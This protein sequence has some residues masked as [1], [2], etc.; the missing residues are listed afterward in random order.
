MRI[1]EYQ[2][3]VSPSSLPGPQASPM[4]SPLGDLAK[5]VQAAAPVVEQ[6]ARLN[7]Q[8]KAFDA[9]SNGQQ[10][11]E[12]L[13]R[14]TQ[15]AMGNNVNAG[16][17]P[18]GAT[19]WALTPA[20]IKANTRLT[21]DQIAS[22]DLNPT[23]K[24]FGE[25]SRGI[26]NQFSTQTQGTLGMEGRALYD[27]HGLPILNSLSNQ[28]GA[29]T[30]QQ[31]LKGKVDSVNANT[32][33]ILD[34]VRSSGV[35]PDGHPDFNYLDTAIH[36][37][38]TNARAIADI[39]GLPVPAAPNSQP[40]PTAATPPSGAA[41][42]AAPAPGG[43]P[44]APA[45]AEGA[46]AA[47]VEP[48]AGPSVPAVPAAPAVANPAVTGP[49]ATDAGS[50]LLAAHQSAAVKAALQ[51]VATTGNASDLKTVYDRY[52]A[53]LHGPDITE[54]KTFVQGK[55]DSANGLAASAS[56]YAKA[57]APAGPPDADGNPPVPVGNQKNIV[58]PIADM[59]R[60]LDTMNLNPE[61][62][63]IAEAD[64]KDRVAL[65]QEQ[66]RQQSV[67]AIGSLNLMAQQGAS[68][69]AI[70]STA[71]YCSLSDGDRAK[72]LA[73]LTPATDPMAQLKQK[74][75]LYDTL[76]EMN[77]TPG[78][79]AAW[80]K[81]HEVNGDGGENYLLT[82]RPVIGPQGVSSLL[83][84][85]FEVLNPTPGKPVP[86]TPF[87][88][89]HNQVQEAWQTAKI[90]GDKPSD[91]DKARMENFTAYLQ[92]TQQNS[93]QQWT[94]DN[95]RKLIQEKSQAIITGHPWMGSPTTEPLWQVEDKNEV[96]AW[97]MNAGQNAGLPGAQSTQAYF[98]LKESGA[99][100]Y[101]APEFKRFAAD[102]AA[103]AT[104]QG[105]PVPSAE[106]VQRMWFMKNQGG[107]AFRGLDLAAPS[108]RAG[109][110][111]PDSIPMP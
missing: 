110:V 41:P 35:G 47:Q 92:R 80:L 66:N 96:P 81:S 105:R 86:V 15:L 37:V 6:F 22:L 72:V 53:L 8:Q 10:L 59:V 100:D 77:H 79:P 56:V 18:N 102:S 34:G 1:P 106:A 76:T 64:L 83:E 88:E 89:L 51:A 27:R 5:T 93:G 68:R 14:K 85:R 32:S 17:G 2:Q 13:G 87:A 33:N 19:P 70:T 49:T 46:P 21:D 107:S 29:H 108:A 44:A 30:D 60:A 40:G 36:A 23:G 28:F 78:G 99:F 67:Q 54:M 61:A 97:F 42:A 98:N 7:D 48:A 38:S 3:E 45:P 55:S 24:N 43:S 9:S 12:L 103:Y 75:A 39:S 4:P 84:A 50:E 25:Y 31:L 111:A 26:L 101:D 82:L 57:S 20:E 16:T 71:T 90:I 52:G 74:A 69:A 62:R 109:A 95:T 73:G 65:Q 11:G 94:L 63:K 58:P 104:K 91:A